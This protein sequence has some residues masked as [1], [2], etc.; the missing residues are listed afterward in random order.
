MNIYGGTK[1]KP[2]PKQRKTPSTPHWSQ[3]LQTEAQKKSKP[4]W[5]TPTRP[6]TTTAAAH[7]AATAAGLDAFAAARHAGQTPEAAEKARTDM[8][9]AVERRLRIENTRRTK[10]QDRHYDYTTEMQPAGALTDVESDSDPDGDVTADM[11][12]MQLSGGNN[13]KKTNKKK[14]N[15]KK[16]NKKKTNKKKT[17]KKKT[18]KK[19]KR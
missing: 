10:N 2:K 4:K 11:T 16:T 14:T 19:Q 12:K 6:I 5:K 18:K 9:T 13:K 3:Q 8:I 7:A 15:K 1:K 17:N